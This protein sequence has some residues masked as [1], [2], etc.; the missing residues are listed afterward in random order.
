MELDFV[1]WFNKSL[2]GKV[3]SPSKGRR[4]SSVG[5][6]VIESV[7]KDFTL[8]EYGLTLVN[9][10]FRSV[11]RFILDTYIILYLNVA[12]HFLGIHSKLIELS[13]LT[14]G[15][16]PVSS[17]YNWKQMLTV[18]TVHMLHIKLIKC[19]YSAKMMRDD[20]YSTL[21]S[22]TPYGRSIS[23]ANDY[24]DTEKFVWPWKGIVANFPVEL[25]N[26]VYVGKS[27]NKLLGETVVNGLDP[28]KV[29]TLWSP[30]GHTG[31][32]VVNFGKDIMGFKNARL[33]E[34]DFELN[35]QGRRDW[36]ST[37]ARGDKLFGWLAREEDYISNS[38]L[39]KHLRDNGNLKTFADIKNEKE[40]MEKVPSSSLDQTIQ[41]KDKQKTE[42]Q[43]IEVLSETCA[44]LEEVMK[45]TDKMTHTFNT[46]MERM[47]KQIVDDKEKILSEHE[48]FMRKLRSQIYELEKHE[49]LSERREADFEDKIIKLQQQRKLNEL[50]TQ[51]QHQLE[52]KVLELV[53]K[54]EREKVALQ[55]RIIDLEKENDQRQA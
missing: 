39:G 50:A 46:E 23:R 24:E 41:V 49:K 31:F 51:E 4:M 26:G 6:S 2:N 5:G 48:N 13:L 47:W 28:W 54:H 9:P 17:A 11:L 32:T 35:G 18:F 55:K 36:Y 34:K 21:V 3:P 8:F 25:E 29:I 27:G 10:Q 40:W 33:F 30:Q 16:C 12:T 15:L 52:Q 20:E 1:Y 22:S 42:M 7:L 44:S 45:E 53:E 19:V 43:K 37:K 14:Q 38:P